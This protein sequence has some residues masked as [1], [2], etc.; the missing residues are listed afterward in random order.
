VLADL[1]QVSLHAEARALAFEAITDVLFA[2]NRD[3]RP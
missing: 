2:G 1:E 3:T